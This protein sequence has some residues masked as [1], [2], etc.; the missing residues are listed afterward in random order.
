MERKTTHEQSR[1]KLPL[2]FKLLL[3]SKV[4]S[5]SSIKSR[6][7]TASVEA[8]S[9]WFWLKKELCGGEGK[10]RERKEERKKWRR[11]RRRG[12]KEEEERK[13]RIN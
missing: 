8:S 10:R 1:T 13:Q 11:E 9:S 6:G 5:H 2:L 4:V 3:F 7:V 12:A